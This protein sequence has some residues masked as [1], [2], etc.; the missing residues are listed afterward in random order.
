MET[1]LYGLWIANWQSVL[2]WG[3]FMKT[4]SQ[5]NPHLAYFCHQIQ[6]QIYSGAYIALVYNDTVRSLPITLRQAKSVCELKS[7][8]H[9]WK[10]SLF[11]CSNDFDFDSWFRFSIYECTRTVTWTSAHNLNETKAN[12][13]EKWR[14]KKRTIK[15]TTEPQL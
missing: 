2:H 9:S 1:N 6:T 12:G 15:R 5:V 14:K 4:F 11:T 8:L 7:L 3:I 10:C 13:K